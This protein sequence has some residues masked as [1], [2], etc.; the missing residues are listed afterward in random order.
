MPDLTIEN[1][2][3]CETAEDF[4]AKVKGSKGTV[5]EVRF[6]RVHGKDTMYDWTCTCPAFKFGGGKQCKHIKATIKRGL[7]CGWNQQF[8]GGEPVEKDGEKKC[9][10]CG[11]D[12]IVFQAGV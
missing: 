10:K 2:Y 5:Y 12:V 1:F 7:R 9:P 3:A 11:A 8:D 4:L 6:G